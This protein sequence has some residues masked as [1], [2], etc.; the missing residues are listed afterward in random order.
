MTQ[1]TL[2]GLL[3]VPLLVALWR[4]GAAGAAAVRRLH[5]RATPSTCSVRPTARRSSRSAGHQSYHDDDGQLRMTTVFV[6]QPDTRIDLFE[7]MGAWLDPDDAAY[8]TTPSTAGRDRRRPA[9]PRAPADGLLPGH[10]GRRGADR[11][12]LR[13]RDARRWR[14]SCRLARATG[15]SSRAT[16][17]SRSTASPVGSVDDVVSAV[18]GRPGR[19]AARRSPCVRDGDDA[20]RQRRPRARP[21]ASRGSAIQLGRHLRRS[22]SRSTSASTPT[23]ADPAPG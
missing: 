16:S 7:V 4:G 19:H 12:R 8:P 5:A 21:T 20:D 17:C 13:R 10:R 1:R 2:A 3:A 9:R 23:S 14:P 15:C 6:T 11:A 18:A 22:R